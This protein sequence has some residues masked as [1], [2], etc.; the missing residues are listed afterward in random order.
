MAH[1]QLRAAASLTEFRVLAVIYLGLMALAWAPMAIA[2]AVLMPL[3]CTP[4]HPRRA[5][6]LWAVGLLAGVMSIV[7]SRALMTQMGGVDQAF[8][9][10]STQAWLAVG[11]AVVGVAVVFWHL[12]WVKSPR[13]MA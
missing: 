10:A 8:T 2:S 9:Q 13:R 6:W 11:W 12:T 5:L 3:F 4:D 7:S 1:V